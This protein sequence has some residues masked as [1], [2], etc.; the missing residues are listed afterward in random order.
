MLKIN[1]LSIFNFLLFLLI[2]A[3]DQIG[4][5][6]TLSPL[7]QKMLESFANLSKAQRKSLGSFASFKE[8]DEARK[9]FTYLEDQ[10]IQGKTLKQPSIHHLYVSVFKL[11][12]VDSTRLERAYATC[13]E[14]IE[15]FLAYAQIQQ[16]PLLKKQLLAEHYLASGQNDRFAEAT[17]QWKK[18]IYTAPDGP[19]RQHQLVALL[20]MLWSHP[21]QNRHNR[22]DSILA[23]LLQAQIEA[24][25]TAQH[26]LDLE[27]F[28]REQFLST[29]L[30]SE[31]LPQPCNQLL[32]ALKQLYFSPAP[33]L[34]AFEEAFRLFQQAKPNLENFIIDSAWRCLNNYCIRQIRAGNSDF[35]TPMSTLFAWAATEKS[36]ADRFDE[37]LLNYCLLLFRT[38][39]SA[40]H[41]TLLQLVENNRSKINEET[42]QLI[43]AYA[44]FLHG[45]Y[46]L[47][48]QHLNQIKGRQL[49][50]GMRI[51]L[52]KLM[53]LVELN[54]QHPSDY[55]KQVKAEMETYENYFS[56]KELINDDLRGYYL[57]LLKPLRHLLRKLRAA[58]NPHERQQQHLAGL[59]L[60]EEK[61]NFAAK[62]W[63]LHKFTVS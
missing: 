9:L 15:D 18:A 63:L 37:D 38:Y 17:N 46:L 24:Q 48:L 35:H 1:F 23:T 12:K 50:Y 16:K 31:P 57:G 45:N 6:D 26:L 29:S 49:I 44:F 56:R 58:A 7:G 3:N 10:S 33:N 47:T 62:E 41:H 52:L 42:Q 60:L 21:G 13:L 40:H 30:E 54:L 14:L 27:R 43:L 53:T 55:A 11:K 59:N 2:L 5:M 34:D 61:D 36:F 25:L 51:H 32:A 39:D 28:G 19:F 22:N 20:Q 4:Y 8:Q